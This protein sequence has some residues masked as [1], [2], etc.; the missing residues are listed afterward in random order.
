MTPY[1]TGLYMII[2]VAF[3]FYPG[4]YSIGSVIMVHY[5]DVLWVVQD[6]SSLPVSRNADNLEHRHS[7]LWSSAYMVPSC[8][9]RSIH[10]H[11]SDR[12]RLDNSTPALL[13]DS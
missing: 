10:R 7:F 4:V 8:Y 9:N 2:A 6:Q 12:R 13:D 3:W 5:I 1:G 11:G